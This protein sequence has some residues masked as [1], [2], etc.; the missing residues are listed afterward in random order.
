MGTSYSV[1]FSHAYLAPLYFEAVFGGTPI[2]VIHDESYLQDKIESEN[3]DRSEMMTRHMMTLSTMKAAESIVVYSS[4]DADKFG[5]SAE[6]LDEPVIPELGK[7]QELDV[8][9]EAVV[10][11]DDYS[12]A[13]YI[14][15]SD[16]GK[17]H[18]IKEVVLA[19]E[20]H[21][22]AD[23]FG[24]SFLALVLCDVPSLDI[25]KY[26][27]SVVR[28]AT[29]DGP[30]DPLVRYASPDGLREAITDAYRYDNDA[31]GG[32]IKRIS[33]FLFSRTYAKAASKLDKVLK[34]A[35]PKAVARGRT[36]GW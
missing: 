16:L 32:E 29:K 22:S 5:G 33:D 34:N 4:R 28:Y 30:I 36:R 12:T 26:G 6:I 17:E 15:G 13:K 2:V 14:M 21:N 3:V 27:C 35:V 8:S 11:V 31:P 1:V 24:K 19:E 23:I 25:L 18:Q 20:F 7:K 10:V 9:T